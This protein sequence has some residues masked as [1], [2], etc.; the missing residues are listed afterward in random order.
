MSEPS[1]FDFRTCNLVPDDEI[2]LVSILDGEI[3]LDK[4]VGIGGEHAKDGLADGEQEDD[5]EGG[6]CSE[7]S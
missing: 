4:I 1:I 2:W 6:D 5:G 7:G 3:V